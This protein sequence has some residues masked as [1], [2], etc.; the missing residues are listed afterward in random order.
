MDIKETCPDEVSQVLSEIVHG[1][2][3]NYSPMHGNSTLKLAVAVLEAV[4]SEV[5]RNIELRN[6]VFAAVHDFRLAQE[7]YQYSDTYPRLLRQSCN[8][9]TERGLRCSRTTTITYGDNGMG[10]C[11]QH[12]HHVPA[13]YGA[14]IRAMDAVGD[15]AAKRASWTRALTEATTAGRVYFAW[16]GGQNLK[17][18]YTGGSS[19]RR[20]EDIRKDKGRQTRAPSKVSWESLTVIHEINGSAKTEKTLHGKLWRHNTEGEWFTVSP[21]LINELGS[22]GI[23]LGWDIRRYVNVT[24][25]DE[26]IWDTERYYTGNIESC[27]AE[28]VEASDDAVWVPVSMIRPKQLASK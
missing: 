20:V 2:W 8:G 23:D 3:S 10:F 18:G 28:S 9:V 21:E 27:S 24:C 11:N 26:S 16:D 12:M 17:I 7:S 4:T 25:S 19:E 6:R 5:S 13:V 1:L 22:L 14:F 15:E